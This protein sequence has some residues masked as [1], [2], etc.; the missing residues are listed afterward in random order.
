MAT[1]Y[2]DNLG[3]GNFGERQQAAAQNAQGMRA[4]EQAMQMNDMNMMSSMK[5]DQRQVKA[6]EQ[7]MLAFQD[8]QQ[9]QRAAQ[10]AGAFYQRL[11]SGDAQGALQVASQ[12]Q[13]DINAL[14]DPSFTVD[15]VAEMIKTPD[16]VEKLKQMSLGMVQMAAGPEQFAKFTAQ[17]AKP[18]STGE[19]TA[20]IKNTAEYK[21]YTDEIRK[22]V[23]NK[24]METAKALQQERDFFVKQVDSYERSLAAGKGAGEARVTTE[25]ALTPEMVART[26]Q[27]E[28]AKI[29]EQTAQKQRDVQVKNQSAFQAYD[30]AAASVKA[31]SPNAGS[32]AFGLAPAVFSDDR[33]FDGA[34]AIL[35]PTIK[36]VVRGAGEGTFT[37]G[38]QV[39]LDK[40]MPTRV[41][42]PEVRMSKMQMLDGF[43]RTKLGQPQ[44]KSEADIMAE[45]GL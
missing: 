27:Q 38:D 13:N 33:L 2:F 19:A 28:A 5:Q 34:I 15:S 29:A 31:L 3:F 36:D 44:A 21:R 8:A 42:S 14:G 32:G 6:D 40:M 16:G 11:Q 45:Y 10:G 22:A 9:K 41:D 7:K 24:D 18:A 35:R 1:N 30:Q 4:N 26:Q 37:E 17:Q 23:A 25:V 39:V 43:I 12:Y 20:Q